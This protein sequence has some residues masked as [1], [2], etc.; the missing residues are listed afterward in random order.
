MKKQYKLFGGMNKTKILCGQLNCSV[1]L[2]GV[3][4][5]YSSHPQGKKTLKISCLVHNNI[6]I[7]IIIIM[8]YIAFVHA[9][10]DLSHGSDSEKRLEYTKY[11]LITLTRLM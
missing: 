3:S 8:L 6:L 2:A 9:S 1:K 4:T 5:R 11:N 7:I 10:I